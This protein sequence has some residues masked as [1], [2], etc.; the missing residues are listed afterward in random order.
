MTPLPPAIPN[1]PWRSLAALLDP[2]RVRLVSGI[3][4][5]ILQCATALPMVWLIR[6][7]FDR[8]TAAA[9]ALSLPVAGAC[10]VTL[11][12]VTAGLGILGQLLIQQAVKSA[13]ARFRKSLLEH[14]YALPKSSHDAR[15]RTRLHD[16]AVHDTERVEGLLLAVAG[17]MI[18][19]GAVAAILA[20]TL[21]FRSPA[22]FLV[23]L[24]TLPFIYLLSR[25]SLRRCQEAATATRRA[26]GNYGRAVHS[27]FRNL[28][29]VWLH[30]GGPREL[31]AHSQRI[32]T[33]GTLGV[34]AT[35]RIVIHQRIQQLS[36]LGISAVVLVI[37]SRAVDRG[38]IT[39]G[40]LLSFYALAALTLNYVRDAGLGVGSVV[41]GRDPWLSLHTF[42]CQPTPP[43]YTGSRRV[44]F[45]GKITLR[46]VSFQYATPGREQ[47]ILEDV[48]LNLAPGRFTALTGANGSGKSTLLQILLGL[49]LPDSGSIR[50]DDVPYTELDIADL[51][52]QI[53][54][55]AQD[56]PLVTGTIRDNIAYAR[57]DAPAHEVEQAA[58][59]A[60][61]HAFIEQLPKGYDTEVGEHGILLSGGQRQRLALARALLVRSTLLILDEP[62]NHVDQEGVRDLLLS[63]RSLHPPPAILVVT[64]V[65]AVVALADEAWTLAN[66]H[67]SRTP[68]QPA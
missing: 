40:E 16:L 46:N 57:P 58:R 14:I 35:W 34:Q 66:G 25:V 48:S 53:G 10:V 36:Y 3:L 67:L 64:H 19:N 38:A 54:V 23:L 11:A 68:S 6:R 39:S 45:S 9:T 22:L 2:V 13:I 56:P 27:G 59:T 29:L 61:A 43:T 8:S 15:E 55:V 62:T 50:A 30:N 26:L 51:R 4:I 21:A 33:L 5:S 52:R 31:A 24:A 20:T 18:P 12:M 32:D 44:S 63:L 28:E 37:G 17:Q 41:L 65:P 7:I 47:R 60:L 1:H 49:Y 42:L